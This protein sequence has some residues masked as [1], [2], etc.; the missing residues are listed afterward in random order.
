MGYVSLIC[1]CRALPIVIHEAHVSW[2]GNSCNRSHPT[3]L[4]PTSSHAVNQPLMHVFLIYS[5]S[6]LCVFIFFSRYKIGEG[7]G[8][9][10]KTTENEI[11]GYDGVPSSS[12][13]QYRTNR[14]HDHPSES[15]QI[16]NPFFFFDHRYFIF[17]KKKYIYFKIFSPSAIC[18]NCLRNCNTAM[19]Q[20]Y[21]RTRSDAHWLKPF[22][23]S[24]A[25]SSV[26]WTMQLNAL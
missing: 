9:Q 16:H 1:I 18:R 24:N 14:N 10:W 5:S 25:S 3:L 11:Y 22:W 23:T 20:L 6:I 8:K 17:R 13:A 15:I 4:P 2:L 12:N 7:G 21:H 19:S 26:S